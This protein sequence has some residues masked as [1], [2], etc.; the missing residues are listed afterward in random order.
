MNARIAR[1]NCVHIAYMRITNTH[2]VEVSFFLYLN[3]WIFEPIS[4]VILFN[5]GT[6]SHVCTKMPNLR[7]LSVR[8]MEKILG[9]FQAGASQSN[10][11]A[12]FGVTQS[13]VQRIWQRFLDTGSVEERPKNGCPRKTSAVDDRYSATLS[14]SQ[15]FEMPRTLNQQLFNTTGITFCEQ[16]I[17]TRLHDN[18]IHSQRPA[19]RPSLTRDHRTTR[20]HF[21]AQYESKNE[22]NTIKYHT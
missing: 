10:A 8:G 14:R 12:K 13:M 1:V 21:A 19:M 5:C 6:R 9:M 15:K 17:R 3:F 18:G 11:A 4:S 22:I 2:Y 16:K 20:R 7:H